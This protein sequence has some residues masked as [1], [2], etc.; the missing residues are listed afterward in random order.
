M[1]EHI[2]DDAQRDAL[3]SGHYDDRADAKRTDADVTRMDRQLARMERSRSR[4]VT[5]RDTLIRN[6]AAS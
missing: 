1:L 2:D 4:L 5:K 6:L 3:V